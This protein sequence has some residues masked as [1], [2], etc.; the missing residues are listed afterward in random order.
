MAYALFNSLYATIPHACVLCKD[1]NKI[2]TVATLPAESELFVRRSLATLRRVRIL[3]NVTDLKVSPFGI[4]DNNHLAVVFSAS[5]KN[6]GLPPIMYILFQVPTALGRRTISC[7]RLPSIRR[8]RHQETCCMSWTSR[9]ATISSPQ[10][11]TNNQ[12]ATTA[13]YNC[14]IQHL[15]RSR[16]D[17]L[18]TTVQCMATVT[19]SHTSKLSLTLTAT[20]SDIFSPSHRHTPHC[21]PCTQST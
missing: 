2:G 20:S 15:P 10:H 5:H 4:F 19:H 12:K 9:T 8:S 6:I 7:G 21:T 17:C 14:T 13:Q 18:P 1:G 11:R 16:P 3:L